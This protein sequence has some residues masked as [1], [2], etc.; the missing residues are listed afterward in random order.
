MSDIPSNGHPENGATPEPFIPRIVPPEGQRAA[1]GQMPSD[2][3][4]ESEAL[5]E[6]L[7]YA[8]P[9][10]TVVG[11]PDVEDSYLP[12]LDIDPAP[13]FSPIS[14]ETPKDIELG[15]LEHLGELRKR[16]L[17]CAIILLLGMMVTWNIGKPLQDWFGAPIIKA[18]QG[19]GVPIITGPTD[20]FTVYFQFSMFSA[21]IL[22]APLMLWQVWLFIEPALTHQERRYT[23]IIVPF[24]SVLFFMGAAL[25][26]EMSPLFYKFFLA[27]Q[28]TGVK[29]FWD[30]SQSVVLMAKMLLV[31]GIMFEVP[32][33][34]I[35][36]NKIGVLQRNVLIE[37]WRHAVVAIFVV[38]AVLTPT[39]DPITLTV[40][41]VPPC[42]LYGLS[43]W[44]VKWL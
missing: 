19:Q 29:A 15:L 5:R 13:A 2:E 18:L 24:A 28:P 9:E 7:P 38:V 37:Y 25:G 20:A 10:L 14:P 35:F 4:D 26:Y 22:T 40:C 8:E 12:P 11:I 3:V 36:L 41:A 43:I 42:L 33:I 32:V 17:A 31:F 6:S 44:L 30:Y 23:V 27:F 39:W 34:V 21:L 1:R 16:L